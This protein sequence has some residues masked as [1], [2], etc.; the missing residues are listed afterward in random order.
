MPRARY[1]R[2]A[3]DLRVKIL[4][5]TFLP[6]ERLPSEPDLATRYRV[7]RPT[8]R[9]ALDLLRDE[10]LIETRHGAGTVV[11]P[12][13]P[14]VQYVHDPRGTS[15]TI[16]GVTTRTHFQKKTAD[17]QAANLLETRVGA[18][19]IECVSLSQR[20]DAPPHAMTRSYIRADLAPERL[21]RNGTARSPWGTELLD[22]LKDTGVQL[23]RAEERVT[24]R[25]ATMEEADPLQV[26]EG[27]PVLSIERRSVDARGR[28]V[29]ASLLVLP[30]DR[31]EA[32]YNVPGPTD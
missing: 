4:N 13:Q 3:D 12:P 15:P 6:G 9:A 31:A 8:L 24:A 25:P 27:A 22:L 30:G 7:G 5:G 20:G 1:H 17:R 10:S 23:A 18:D 19:L 11:Q 29:E 2:I 14:R 21:P 16:E 32:H 28:V 26:E